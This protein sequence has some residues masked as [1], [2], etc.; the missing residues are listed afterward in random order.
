[1]VTQIIP[2]VVW[3]SY[4]DDEIC[5]NGEHYISLVCGGFFKTIEDMDKF[6]KEYEEAQYKYYMGV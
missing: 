6:W 1:M 4:N 3:Y 5:W 2:P